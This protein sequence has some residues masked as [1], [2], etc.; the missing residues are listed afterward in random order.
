MDEIIIEFIR[1]NP[2]SGLFEITEHCYNHDPQ[3][4]ARNLWPKQTC[5]TKV[6]NRLNSLVRRGWLICEDD[7]HKK[8]YYLTGE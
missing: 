7:G 8:T 1:K 3:A 5:R 4:F 6:S 2:G